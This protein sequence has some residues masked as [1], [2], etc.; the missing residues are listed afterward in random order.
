M[1]TDSAG[2]PLPP[3]L[4]PQG[5]IAA[6]Q[7]VEAGTDPLALALRRMLRNPRTLAALAVVLIML[8]LAVLAGVIAP[9]SY[10]EQVR[11][12]ELSPPGSEFF[13][14]SDRLGRDIL[15]RIMYGAR[16][17][18]AVGIVATAL[19]LFIGVNVGLI[20]AYFGGWV[21]AVLMRITDTFSAFPS[22]MLAIPITALFDRPSFAIVF[23][24][25]GIVGWTGIARVVRGQVLTVK[26]MDYVTAAR[27]LG[28][29][30]TRI[31]FRHILPNCVSPIIVIA[32]LSVGGNILAEAGLSFLGLSVQD[33]FPSW[34]GMLTIA[35][36]DFHLYW[37]VAV[38]PGLAIVLTVLSFNLLGDG[39]RDA[40]DPKRSAL[41]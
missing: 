25:L 16:V 32:T 19:S 7:P 11:G 9:Y 28:S 12:H 2:T 24:A 20:S 18:L 30:N 33:P 26:E 1:A 35:R 3:V 10:K 5:G 17:S 36:N 4:V 13:F 23:F 37:W 27:A 14:G 34:G 38:F 39:L 41:R 21:D 15:S 29:R 22:I 8:L 31:I 40:L 6:P